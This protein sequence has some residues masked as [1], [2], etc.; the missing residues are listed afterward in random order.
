VLAEEAATVR[1]DQ[2]APAQQEDVFM[3]GVSTL[4]RLGVDERNKESIA[5]ES[6]DVG[7]V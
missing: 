3:N 1:P 5:E 4:A 6:V 2:H 7:M